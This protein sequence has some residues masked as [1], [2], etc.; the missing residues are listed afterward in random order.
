MNINFPHLYLKETESTNL[1]ASELLSKI[2]PPNGFLIITDY[3]TAGKGQYGRVWQSEKDKNLLFSL[4]LN[5]L[6]LQA[7]QLFRLHLST[8]LSIIRT[9]DGLGISQLKIKWPNDIY[10]NDRKLAGILIQNQLKGSLVEHSVIG[11]GMNVNQS[12]FPAE[13]NA[14]SIL[15]ETGIEFEREKIL[16]NIRNQI[17]EIMYMSPE[18]AWDS[19]MNEYNSNLYLKNERIVLTTKNDERII[20][21]L[22]SVTLDGKLRINNS[23]NLYNDYS[24]GEIQYHKLN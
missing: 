10:R 22:H 15:L 2:N 11:I 6:N 21:T 4:I 24:F 8:S 5:Q 17:L 9:L 19:L 20:G 16:E 12:Q 18:N 23:Q 13:L 3:Q 7:N 14:T 1:V